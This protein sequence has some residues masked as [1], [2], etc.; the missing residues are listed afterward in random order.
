MRIEIRKSAKSGKK[1]EPPP[2]PVPDAVASNIHSGMSVAS[3]LIFSLILSRL[4]LSTALWLSRRRRRFSFARSDCLSCA[5]AVAPAPVDVVE[6]GATLTFA[7]FE[8][9]GAVAEEGVP[10]NPVNVEEDEANDPPGNELDIGGDPTYP[11]PALPPLPP[12]PP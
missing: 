2:P 7:L 3:S 4:R 10:V 6:P 12:N 1:E 9:L 8:P 5:A 11:V